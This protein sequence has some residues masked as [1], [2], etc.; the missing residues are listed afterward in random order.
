MRSR[1]PC[2]IFHYLSA[3]PVLS[4]LT[5]FS[6]S[7]LQ[8]G[9]APAACEGLLGPAAAPEVQL[10]VVVAAVFVVVVVEYLSLFAQEPDNQMTLK[11][12]NVTHCII[13]VRNQLKNVTIHQQLE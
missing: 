4:L 8:L 6:L 5:P 13:A 10:T 12:A 11:L 3:E 9:A 2:D 1:A 7:L